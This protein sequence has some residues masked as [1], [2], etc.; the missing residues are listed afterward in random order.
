MTAHALLSAS[1]FARH[2]F[3]LTGRV[4]A[5]GIVNFNHLPSDV[6]ILRYTIEGVKKVDRKS[7]NLLQLFFGYVRISTWS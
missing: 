2:P 5:F 3:M 6:L 7:Y 1:G 4:A